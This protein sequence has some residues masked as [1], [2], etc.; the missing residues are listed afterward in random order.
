VAARLAVS[1][2]ELQRAF[3]AGGDGSFSE[4]LFEI[5]M[6]AARRLLERGG[7]SRQVAAS[8][9]ATAAAR[10]SQ[11]HSTPLRRVALAISLTSVR[12]D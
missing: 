7:S 9:S 11:K 4:Y 1:E 2:R 10:S 6:S 12:S 8:R 5:R 3:S